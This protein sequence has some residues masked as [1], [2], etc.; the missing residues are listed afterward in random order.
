MATNIATAMNANA[1][2]S[3]VLTAAANSPAAGDVT[4]S[5]K[6]AGVSGNGYKATASSFSAF[7]PAS[8]SLSGGVGRGAAERVPGQVFLQRR[9]R[10]LLR[11]CGLPDRRRGRGQRGQYRG[12]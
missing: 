12:L 10:Q 3:A 5:A 7:S 4:F 2:F 11:L 8:A 1:T 6:V 9:Q